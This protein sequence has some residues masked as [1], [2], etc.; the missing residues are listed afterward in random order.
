MQ[1]YPGQKAESHRK[2]L[3]GT[4]LTQNSL[5]VSVAKIRTAPRTSRKD[6]AYATALNSD[7]GKTTTALL[8]QVLTQ[9]SFAFDLPYIH[10]L[11]QI[12]K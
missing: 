10:F 4:E 9:N 5:C 12:C 11:H 6:V 2:Y 1:N 7:T 3:V 8:V